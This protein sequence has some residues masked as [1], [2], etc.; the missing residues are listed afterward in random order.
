MLNQIRVL[1]I[2]LQNTRIESKKEINVLGVIF[3][4]KLNWNAHAASA[5]CK[6]RKSLY[7]LRLLRKF[8][9]DHEMRLLLDSYFFSVLYY[10]AVIWLTPELSAVMKQALLSISANALRNCM[11]SNCSEVSFDSIHKI[12]NKC[13]PSQIMSYQQALNLHK[14]LNEIY[15]SC[16][17]EHASLISNLVCTRRQLRFEIIRSNK[18]K[19]GMNTL[20]NKFLHI[21]KLISLDN[22]NYSFVHFKK[23]MKIQFLKCIT[24]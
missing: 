16:T 17:T 2:T 22:L 23:V 24:Y 10:N 21:S 13:T 6:A 18:C 19:I 11:L 7:A 20:S 14:K 5:I 9:N 3:D 15:V 1:S 12:C 8:F 4:S